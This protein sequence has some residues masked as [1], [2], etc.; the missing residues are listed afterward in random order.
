MINDF[1]KKSKARM[2]QSA[3]RFGLV[4]AATNSSRLWQLLASK[5]DRKRSV[6]L[7]EADETHDDRN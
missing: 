1:V 2:R 7:D 5:S 3:W 4:I 6:R